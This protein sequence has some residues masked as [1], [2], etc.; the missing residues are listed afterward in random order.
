MFVDSAKFPSMPQGVYVRLT[1]EEARVLREQMKVF[2]QNLNPEGWKLP[3]GDTPFAV[4]Y[5][6]LVG[7]LASETSTSFQAQTTHGGPAKVRT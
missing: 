3:R 1:H 7:A 6:G 4:L 5:K 2:W